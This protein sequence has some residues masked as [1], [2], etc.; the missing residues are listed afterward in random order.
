MAPR[1]SQS[2]RRT[3]VLGVTVAATLV[4]GLLLVSVL[5]N[6]G[7]VRP[8]L[9]DEQFRAGRTDV[10]ADRIRDDGPA[11]FS[12]LGAGR[13]RDIYVQHLGAKDAKGWVAVAARA[14]GQDDRTCS[15]TWTGT[16]FRDPCTRQEFP[17]DG[18]GLDRY[19]TRVGGAD[20]RF[21]YVDLRG[22]V[23]AGDE[24]G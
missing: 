21:L 8:Q 20:H 11:L 18:T 13:G 24:A 2:T 15:L 7:T 4:G 12:G 9:G 14:P 17:A 6:R 16:A 10:L 23:E 22:V 3:V 5:A 19:P 1:R